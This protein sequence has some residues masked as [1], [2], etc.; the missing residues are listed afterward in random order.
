MPDS[1]E[2]NPVE[3]NPDA[4]PAK[5][6]AQTTDYR[7]AGWLFPRL[8][9]VVYLI[10]FVSWG[11]Q[12]RGLAGPEGIAPLDELMANVQ[13]YEAREKTSLLLEYPTL[14]HWRSDAVFVEVVIWGCCALSLVVLAGGCQ[15]PLLLLLWLGYLS[16]A[17][18]GDVFMNFQWDALLLETGLIAVF[19]SPWRVWSPLTPVQSPPR[20]AWLLLFWLLFRLMFLSGLVKWAGGDPVWRDCT[21]LLFHYETQ[22]LPN[23][24]SWFAHHLPR[25]IHVAG[26][27]AM[28]F[29][30]LALPFAIFLGRWGRRTAA[31]GFILL[32]LLVMATGNYTY[33][34]LLT[35]FLALCLLDDAV[36]PRWIRS[37]LTAKAN[38]AGTP[39]FMQ[40]RQ[41][42]GLVFAIPAFIL[43]LAA[44]DASL[45]GRLPGYARALPAWCHQFYGSTA[46][47]RSFNAYGLFQSMT[48]ERLEITLEASDDGILW[49]PLD[50]KWKPGDLSLRPRQV[51]PHQP[52]LD[53]QM[54]FAALSPGYLPQR[55]SHPQ[56]PVFWFGRFMQ[57][58]LQHKKPVWELLEEP[59]L[60]R[61]KITHLRA[62]LWRYHFTSPEERKESGSWWRREFLGF[63]SPA[64]SLNTTP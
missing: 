58:L 23:G 1:A 5:S 42:P 57:S 46:S 13:A 48:K 55:D 34:N 38:P 45:Q 17:V 52:R 11:A 56:S 35:I 33:F 24:L 2:P 20:A 53:W 25:W 10:A 40:L 14:F 29:I 60:P 3:A 31:A 37:R 44:A 49:L 7:L 59:P 63:Y 43:T 18:T 26:C 4:T 32:M 21:A 36:W 62:R 30:E 47:L 28:H 54:W 12:W 15:G 39:W 50:F 27:G 9:A 51:A 6:T 8:L 19:A 41:W 16:L 64:L 61:E 22:P